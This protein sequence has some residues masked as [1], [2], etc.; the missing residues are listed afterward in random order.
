MRAVIMMVL[1]TR[2]ADEPACK[3]D[4]VIGGHPSRVDVA[5]DL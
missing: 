1:I 2:V 4:P 5:V 3:P